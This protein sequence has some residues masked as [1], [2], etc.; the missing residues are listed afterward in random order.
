MTFDWSEYLNL[1]QE[2]AGDA[3][4][5]PNEEA[6]LRSSVSRAY[7]APFCKARNHLRDID[8][9]QILSVDPPKVNVHT[10]VRNQFKN[11]SDK[12][13]KKMGTDLNRLRLRR[14]KADYKDV[15]SGLSQLST[16]SLKTTYD[17]ISALNTL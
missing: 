1:A 13:R 14:N 6:K 4:S 15:V 17:I 12:S 11:S 16:V 3:V 5:S 7:Y 10:Y 8:G 2:L 9:D